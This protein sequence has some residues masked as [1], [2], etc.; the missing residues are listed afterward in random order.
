M[1]VGTGSGI[2]SRRA[3]QTVGPTGSVLGIDLSEGMID[4]ARRSVADWEGK[5]PEFRVMDAEALDLVDASVDAVISLCCVRHLPN[6]ERAIDEMRRVLKPGGRL[7]VSYGHVRPITL[8]PLGWHIARRLV[9]KILLPVRPQLVGPAYLTRLA[10]QLL[11]EPTQVIA[12]EWDDRD[13][14][15]ALVRFVRDAGFERVEASWWGHEVIFDSAEEFWEAQT[16]IVTQVRK[17]LLEAPPDVVARLKRAFLR[18][19]ETILHEGG[20]LIYP[21]GAFY[22][23]AIRPKSHCSE[24]KGSGR[25]GTL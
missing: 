7:V 21:Y 25:K 5:P 20:T 24:N 8:L 12:A 13:P 16:S 1:D 15:G 14:Q 22:A 17:R 23:S 9:G 19:A 3:A 2:A 18:K 11:P 4:T 10:T 6:I